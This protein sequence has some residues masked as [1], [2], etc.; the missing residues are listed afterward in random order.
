MKNQ[1]H[2][3]RVKGTQTPTPVPSQASPEVADEPSNE[4][5]D[6][7]FDPGPE[8]GYGADMEGK[9][10]L[11]QLPLLNVANGHV[12]SR[13]GTPTPRVYGLR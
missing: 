1:A 3:Y 7:P 12:R 8:D 10:P 6:R 2:T 13:T 11:S 4:V 5:T 9:R